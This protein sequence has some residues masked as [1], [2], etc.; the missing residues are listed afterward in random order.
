MGFV[1]A[2]YSQQRNDIHFIGLSR[3]LSAA[4]VSLS[5]G[6]LLSTE[7]LQ[8]EES[9]AYGGLWANANGPQQGLV[10]LSCY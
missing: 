6:P 9:A 3:N 1:G 4:G 8:A 10:E 7:R 2:D 5:L